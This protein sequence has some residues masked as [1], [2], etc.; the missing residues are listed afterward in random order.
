MSLAQRLGTA[1]LLVAVAGFGLAP[2]SQAHDDHHQHHHSRKKKKKAYDKGY[3]QGYRR[4]I[5]N[6][7]R[8]YESVYAPDPRRVVLA[9]S[10]WIGPRVYA[11][12]HGMGHR[13]VI[14]NRYR[15]HAPVVAPSPWVGPPVYSHPHGLHV[16]GR[17]GLNL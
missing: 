7:Y 17:F 8:P 15:R 3:R 16:N 4:A 13:R 14:D 11:Y 12:P 9:P 5:E 2:E 10:P 6:S 1:A